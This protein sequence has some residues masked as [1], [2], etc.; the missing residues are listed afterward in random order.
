[1]TDQAAL[2]FHGGVVLLVGMLVGFPYGAVQ[3][4]GKD[5]VKEQNWR[6]AHNQNLQNGMLLLIVGAC[7]G[8]LQLGAGRTVM[9]WL[10]IFAAYCDMAALFIRA[11]TG[12][13]GRL[14]SG[15]LPNAATFAL[16]CGVLVG[17]LGGAL[18]F[19][20]GAWRAIA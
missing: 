1:M 12:Y 5:P 17:Q 10:F 16:F 3:V 6:L 8:L 15:P 4:A 19:I 13:T 20:Y 9:A 11:R 14:P 7:A 18:L 2:V